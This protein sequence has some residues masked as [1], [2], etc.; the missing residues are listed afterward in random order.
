ML[1]VSLDLKHPPK[2]CVS[3]ALF[4]VWYYW[5]VVKSLTGWDL[6]EVLRSSGYTYRETMGLW[7][8]LLALLLPNYEK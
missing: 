4:S 3:E 6:E 7:P 1:S 2:T 5:E 8:H